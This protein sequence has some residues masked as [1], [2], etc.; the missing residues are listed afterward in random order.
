MP[1]GRMQMKMLPHGLITVLFVVLLK[2]NVNAQVPDNL[3]LLY[4]LADSSVSRIIHLLPEKGTNVFVKA[5][6]AGDYSIFRN[7]IL[8]G[9]QHSGHNIVVAENESP[10]GSL[11]FTVEGAKIIYSDTF[12][13]GFLGDV[14]VKRDARLNVSFVIAAKGTESRAETF[15]LNSTD[16]INYDEI[17]S[18]ENSAIPFTRAEI[19][20][21]PFFSTIWEPVV[22]IGSAAVAVYLF[23]T[24][25][26]K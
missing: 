14:K 21:E 19:P 9:L 4:R 17:G 3:E 23:F 8:S 20:P 6:L 16:T 13:D 1:D 11:F 25:R 2:L 7:R 12:R 22:A 5:D 10:S 15:S 24:V 18:L 26:G